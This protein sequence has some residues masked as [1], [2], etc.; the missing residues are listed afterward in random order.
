[1]L[2]YAF[3]QNAII[4]G[5]FISILCPVVGTFLVLKDIL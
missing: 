3:M 5:I 4:A 2:Q 1:M